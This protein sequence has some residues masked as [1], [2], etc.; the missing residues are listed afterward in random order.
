LRH[1]GASCRHDFGTETSHK[2]EVWSVKTR[3]QR[4]REKKN[5][6]SSKPCVSILT[7]YLSDG[8]PRRNQLVAPT[9]EKGGERRGGAPEWGQ[10]ATDP[11]APGLLFYFFLCQLE[12]GGKGKKKREGKKKTSRAAG[13]PTLSALASC[14]RTTSFK[15]LKPTNLLV[16]QKGGKRE[17]KE[18]KKKKTLIEAAGDVWGLGQNS[19]NPSLIISL[20]ADPRSE[21]RER[22]KEKGKKKKKKGGHVNE[23]VISSDHVI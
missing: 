10:R 5:K 16:Q 7:E 11:S 3:R 22:R 4:E 9:R 18:G 1:L 2:T 15:Q 6:Q 12:E 21:R 14:H 13:C 19:S 20:M 8:V 17:K 23:G